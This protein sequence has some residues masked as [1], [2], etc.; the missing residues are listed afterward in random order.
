MPAAPARQRFASTQQAAA[1]RAP[2]LWCQWRA[3]Q[4][5]GVRR[6]RVQATSPV[7]EGDD[8]WR[9]VNIAR[10][11][12]IGAAFTLGLEALLFPMFSV[13]TKLQFQR[14][15]RRSPPPAPPL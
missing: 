5:G 15:V 3:G 13:A 7:A 1:N 12:G 2:G 14:T 11:A 8:S 4:C 10:F 6:G 9:G